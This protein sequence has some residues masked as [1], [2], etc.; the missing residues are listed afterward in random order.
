[1]HFILVNTNYNLKKIEINIIKFSFF[2]IIV[3]MNHTRI[4]DIFKRVYLTQVNMPLGRWKIIEKDFKRVY[5]TQVNVPLGRWKI[6]NH[7]QTTLKIKYANEDNCGISG[8]NYKNT[9]QIQTN[10]E[11]DDN[12]YIY[13]MGYESVHS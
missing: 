12:K 6:H 3:I 11:L 9:T 13:I 8:M 7:I 10:N 5:L 4:L 2:Y 1:M